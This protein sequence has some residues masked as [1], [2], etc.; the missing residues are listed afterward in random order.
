MKNKI[1]RNSS[2]NL[3]KLTLK[4]NMYFIYYYDTIL[5]EPSISFSCDI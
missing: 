2:P 3:A 5:L 4:I 1:K